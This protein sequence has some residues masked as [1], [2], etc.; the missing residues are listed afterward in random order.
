MGKHYPQQPL[1][2][3]FLQQQTLAGQL[4]WQAAA[5]LN[6]NVKVALNQNEFLRFLGESQV[7]PFGLFG[8]I[9]F[10]C[11][12]LDVI[13]SSQ[14]TLEFIRTFKEQFSA[15]PPMLGLSNKNSLK[16]SK[17]LFKD[18]L[19]EILVLP[20]QTSVLK[21]ALE[22]FLANNQQINHLS[23]QIKISQAYEEYPV[24][25]LR[26]YNLFSELAIKQEFPLETLFRDFI[27]EIEYFVSNL[28][29]EFEAG[30]YKNCLRQLTSVKSVSGTLGASQLYHISKNIELKIKE[31]QLEE[32]GNMIPFL[33][34]KFL[35]LKDYFEGM[36]CNKHIEKVLV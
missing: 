27:N 26:S 35:I 4:V 6:C 28:I 19:D 21:Q 18:D 3:L 16:L 1:S 24:L 29:K 7:N 32:V 10:G 20:D 30:N 14:K 25:N 13:H 22:S 33:I 31:N 2:L 11:L 36:P 5:P 9:S 17:S 15:L 23:G 8:Q 34:E 12:I